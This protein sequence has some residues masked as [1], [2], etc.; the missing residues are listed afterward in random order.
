MFKIAILGMIVFCGVVGTL[1]FAALT[2]RAVRQ[3][4]NARALVINN[5]NGVNEGMFV[6][7]GGMDQWIQIRGEDRDN[8]M[9]LVLHGGPGFSYIPFTE[10]LRPWEK[11]FTIVQWDRRGVGRTFG[12]NG[13]NSSVKM[14]FDQMA[15]DGVELTE[16]LTKHLNKQKVILLGHSMG[17]IVGVLMAKQRPDLFY[18]YVG[19]DQIVDGP[20]NEAVSYDLL[21][22]RVR[23]AGNLKAEKQLEEIGAPPYDNVKGWWTKQKLITATDPVAPEFEKTF[24]PMVMFEPSYS[25]MDIKDLGTGY[26]FSAA[27]ML[28]EIMNFDVRKAGTTFETPMFIVEGENDVLDPTQLAV[29]YFSSIEAPKKELVIMK[30]A[31]HQ[32]MLIMREQFLKELLVRVIPLVQERAKSLRAVPGIAR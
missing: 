9:L 13:K 16:F 6:K 5:P 2:Y 21:V 32:A 8:P 14:T 7:L 20:R 22:K 26:Q 28:S 3:R 10:M 23:D 11:H 30:G 19:T 18:A 31:G 1:L 15:R 17:S 25:L 4:Q 24:F 29:E 12:R 27:G